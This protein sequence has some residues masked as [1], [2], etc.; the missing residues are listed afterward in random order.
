MEGILKKLI[1]LIEKECTLYFSLLELLQNE[2]E[3][4]V[5]SKIEELQGVIK[6]KESLLLKIRILDEQR[7]R[8]LKKIGELLGD[9]EKELTMTRLYSLV[10]EPFSSELKNSSSKL[11]ALTQSIQELNNS[12]RSLLV[13]SI[14]LVRGSMNL[15]MNVMPSSH[16]YQRNGSIY[17]G[18]E[19]GRNLSSMF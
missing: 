9:N 19:S 12:N 17:N 1:D 5:G 11:L 13:H 18:E 8:L 14:E 2:K 7:H 10:D 15:L 3:A 16:V 6:G 4:L